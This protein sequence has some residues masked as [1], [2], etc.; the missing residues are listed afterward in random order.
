MDPKYCVLNWKFEDLLC[1]VDS[2]LL[3]TFKTILFVHFFS[4]KHSHSFGLT[5]YEYQS[6]W[7]PITLSNSKEWSSVLVKTTLFTLASAVPTRQTLKHLTANRLIVFRKSKR[8]S[9]IFFHSLPSPVLQEQTIVLF[10][11]SLAVRTHARARALI[12]GTQ[13]S[14]PSEAA[15]HGVVDFGVVYENDKAEKH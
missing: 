4:W 8:S 9:S 11:S 7:A 5:P 15:M 13:G 3:N 10:R 14:Q 1:R 2:P 6:E 12:L